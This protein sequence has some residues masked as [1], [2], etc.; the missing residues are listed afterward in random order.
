M[1]KET[2]IKI[3]HDFISRLKVSG[4]KVTSAYL[5]GSAARNA[6]SED[7][8]IDIA[9][10]IDGIENTFLAQIELMKLRRAIDLRIE[11][12]PFRQEDTEDPDPFFQEI[13]RTGLKVT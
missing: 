8:D 7:S 10:V 12:H 3:A 1:D 13:I 2:A 4:W 6:G 9:V 5:F 11:P